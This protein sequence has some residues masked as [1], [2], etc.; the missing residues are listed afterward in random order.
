MNSLATLATAAEESLGANV[1]SQALGAESLTIVGNL[2][3]FSAGC[4]VLA[5]GF[6]G[7]AA[8]ARSAVD[9]ADSVHHMSVAASRQLGSW[10]SAGE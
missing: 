3:V 6:F 7:N 4:N 5:D 1:V 8:V 10:A 2:G 9:G